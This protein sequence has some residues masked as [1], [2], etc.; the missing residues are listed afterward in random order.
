[1]PQ[2]IET[3]HAKN[4]ANFADIISFCTGY[5]ATY[6]PSKTA[7]K[8]SNL[9]TLLTNAQQAINAVNV[10][11]TAYNNAVNDRMLAFKPLK[12]LATR[13]INS[14][15]ATDAT[16]EVVKDA[17]AIN[18]KIQGQRAK[19]IEAPTNPNT[20]A[21]NTISTSQQSYD[22]QIEHLDKLVILL[23]SE[24]SYLPNE[25]D[26]NVASIDN[27]K[28]DLK[29][30]NDAV[31]SSYTDISNTRIARNEILYKSKTGLYDIALDV[32]QYVKSIFGASSPQYKQISGVKFTPLKK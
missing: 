27:L 17:K 9:N 16:D 11:N 15:N 8:T 3:G 10:K 29:A 25:A 32:K 26:L 24:A 23:Q 12:P 13:I 4:V 20:P 6:N 2:V 28:N 21:P 1:M 14:L 31:T 18:R 22:Q 5:G 19:A 7:L 30:K